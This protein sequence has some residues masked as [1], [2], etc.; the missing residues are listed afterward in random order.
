MSFLTR[1]HNQTIT[2]WD[3]PVTDKFGARTFATPEQITGRWEDRTDL[4]IDS[5]G[6]ES[7]SKAFVF[8]GQDLDSEGWLFLGTSSEANPKDVDG[9]LE[10]R[11]FIKTPN[12][13]A[14]DFE[15]KA[16]L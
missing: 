3:T 6:R 15:R 11:Q 1:N 2:Y 14:T 9:A 7:V 5:T 4:F 12:L 16:I 10:I 8:V 13:K